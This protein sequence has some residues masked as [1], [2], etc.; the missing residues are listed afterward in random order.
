VE[1]HFHK[2]DLTDL[3]FSENLETNHHRMP[4]RRHSNV[5][6]YGM[7]AIRYFLV[8]VAGISTSFEN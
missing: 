2:P 3:A 6:F 1:P 5:L 4:R 8:F 7:A